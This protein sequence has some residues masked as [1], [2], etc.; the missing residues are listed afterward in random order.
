MPELP[1][2]E[3]IVRDLRRLVRGATIRDVVV[4][5][6]DLVAGDAARFAESVRGH[7]IEAVSRRA[8]NIV[9]DLGD[10]R[11][12]VNLGMTGR[13]LVLAP[14]EEEPAHLGVRFDLAD[15]RRLVYQ[16]V[17]R[18]GRLEVVPEE[19]WRER[20]ARLGIEPLSSDL[21]PEKLYEITRKSRTPIKPWLMDQRRVVGIGNIYASEILFRARISPLRHAGRIT[22]RQASSLVDAC[23]EVLREAIEFRGTTLLDYRDANGA[24]GA[25]SK[26]LR[27]YGREGEPC[28]GCDGKV[29]RI[30][31]AGRSTFYCP[32]C[33]K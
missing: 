30:V 1:E 10:D 6:A 14:G 28:V 13:L 24:R 16:D 3:T 25:F 2:V 12:V 17:R 22:R 26:R 23:R 7:T 33:Q 15:A 21:T 18:F 20:A 19:A 9:L 11:L 32:S 5:K 31:Q 27:V 29:R 4:E 8:K